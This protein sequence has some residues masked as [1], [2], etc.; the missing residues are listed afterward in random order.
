MNR[1]K[2]RY[3]IRE[4]ERIDEI[5]DNILTIKRKVSDRK[6]NRKRCRW[7]KCSKRAGFNSRNNRR[8]RWDRD[9]CYCKR[10]YQSARAI[11]T[12]RCR[13]LQISRA[14]KFDASRIRSLLA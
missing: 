8:Y 3:L 14:A 13:E 9:H 12:A 1:C 10:H 4:G 7:P 5:S 11:Q 2:E 6:A